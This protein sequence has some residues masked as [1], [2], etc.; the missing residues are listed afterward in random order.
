MGTKYDEMPPEELRQM[1]H[2]MPNACAWISDKGS[3]F[4]KGGPMR[5]GQL[6]SAVDRH[7]SFRFRRHHPL[8][9]HL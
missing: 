1:A 3:H 2:L 8:L 9:G 7:R 6:S 4:A 5:T